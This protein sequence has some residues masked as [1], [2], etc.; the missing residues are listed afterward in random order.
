MRSKK[1]LRTS[2][3]LIGAGRAVESVFIRL[4]L[5]KISFAPLS[6]SMNKLLNFKAVEALRNSHKLAQLY[7]SFRINYKFSIYDRFE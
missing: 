5:F 1:L 6:L 2:S 4:S 7:V 3:R